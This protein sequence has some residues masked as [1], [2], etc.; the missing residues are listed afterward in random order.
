MTQHH[1]FFALFLVLSTIGCVGSPEIPEPQG[2][3][4][5]NGLDITCDGIAVC[6]NGFCEC[7]SPGYQLARGFCIQDTTKVVFFSTDQYAGLMDTLIVELDE[8]PWG[9]EWPN[10]TLIGNH[11]IAGYNYDRF[12]FPPLLVTRRTVMSL[13]QPQT[14]TMGNDSVLIYRIS[15]SS[16]FNGYVN[17]DWFCDEVVFSG[18]LVGPDQIEGQII[19]RGCETNLDSPRPPEMEPGFPLPV[20]FTRFRPE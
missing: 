9:Y 4:C 2:E 7:T 13:L 15:S 5:A 6:D 18:R 11:E 8:E 1:L 10:D 19:L 16:F 3:E 20:T 12:P 17:G 14:P